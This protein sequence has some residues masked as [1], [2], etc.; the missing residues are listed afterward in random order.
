M[1]GINIK[2]FVKENESMTQMEINKDIAETLN[3]LKDI[4][5]M[6]DNVINNKAIT[7]FV[8]AIPVG[9]SI[10]NPVKDFY[11]D[12]KCG[13]Y[14]N[15]TDEQYNEKLEDMESLGLILDDSIKYDRIVLDVRDNYV[16]LV[17]ALTEAQKSVKQIYDVAMLVE[18]LRLIKNKES[19]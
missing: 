5:E 4:S 17:N 10:S 18:V 9:C 1:A 19:E 3:Y 11:R 8:C 13:N 14:A 2:E 16:N 6:A 7:N 15:L 12:C